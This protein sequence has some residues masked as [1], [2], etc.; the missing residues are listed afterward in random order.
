MKSELK[1]YMGVSILLS[2]MFIKFFEVFADDLDGNKNM[3]GLSLIFLGS[4]LIGLVFV[5]REKWMV[6][7]PAVNAARK[8][9]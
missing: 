7:D 8:S 2:A 4:L 1:L 5:I 6:T 3:L 9:A